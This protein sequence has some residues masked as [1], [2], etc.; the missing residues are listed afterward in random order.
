MLCFAEDFDD[1]APL[2]ALQGLRSL[3]LSSTRVTSV[4]PH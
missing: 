1:V 4:V 3:S 2:G